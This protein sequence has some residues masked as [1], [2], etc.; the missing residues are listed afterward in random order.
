VAHGRARR[1]CC[2]RV[3]TTHL[4]RF[5]LVVDTVVGAGAL[6]GLAVADEIPALLTAALVVVLGSSFLVLRNP[7]LS[8]ALQ[9]AGYGWLL[10]TLWNDGTPAVWLPLATAAG[11]GLVLHRRLF[12]AVI[13]AFLR[14]LATLSRRRERF[15][16]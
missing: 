3:S 15:D 9:A 5:D 11:L 2:P 10:W 12:R 4:G 6:V 14:G 8:M 16:L 7:A 1:A 13:P